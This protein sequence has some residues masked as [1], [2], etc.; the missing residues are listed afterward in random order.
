[1]TSSVLASR[2]SAQ[3]LTGTPAESVEAVAERLLAVQAQD[4]RGSRLAVRIRSR[5]LAAVDFD[6]ALSDRRSVIVAWLNRGTL[7]LELGSQ[8]GAAQ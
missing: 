1:M 6:A 7:H 5:D 8:K 3:L 4:L 2:M